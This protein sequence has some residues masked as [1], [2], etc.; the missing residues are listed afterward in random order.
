MT[1]K[2]ADSIN[3]YY[4]VTTLSGTLLAVSRWYCLDSRDF[5]LRSKWQRQL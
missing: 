1:R 2:L 4:H 5:S 3:I